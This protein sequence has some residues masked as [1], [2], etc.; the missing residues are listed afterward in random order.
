[1]ILWD[2]LFTIILLILIAPFCLI[3]H[4]LGHA[5]GA[6]LMGADYV[7]LV[8]GTGKKCWQTMCKGTYITVRQL[9][10]FNSYTASEK[11]NSYTVN[12]QVLISIMGPLFSLLLAMIIFI[13]YAF[14]AKT[15]FIF[16]L[17]LFNVW[18]G[19]VNF[20]PFKV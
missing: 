18:I 19:L 17:H 11:K 14:I 15:P 12:E 3:F 5:Y 7:E 1:M 8:I 16:L 10:L 4:E 2:V 20:I 9:F 6:K 13:V